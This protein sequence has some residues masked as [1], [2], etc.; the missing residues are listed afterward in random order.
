MDTSKDSMQKTH[1]FLVRGNVR[2]ARCLPVD[3]LV[4]RVDACIKAAQ[5]MFRSMTLP[6]IVSQTVFDLRHVPEDFRNK[7]A[8]KV[9]AIGDEAWDDADTTEYWFVDRVGVW[10][11][12]K[13]NS[14]GGNADFSTVTSRHLISR[15]LVK[16]HED[17][18]DIGVLGTIAETL[19]RTFHEA[20]GAA[21]LRAEGFRKTALKMSDI[22]RDV[23]RV[24]D[25]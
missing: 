10:Y 7:S 1:D 17:L 18:A 2:G 12:V 3:Q 5:P 4:E 22:A 23:S 21:Q 20:D 15:S 11:W 6:T 19:R 8:F 14:A 24:A 13:C 9:Y 25:R 16:D